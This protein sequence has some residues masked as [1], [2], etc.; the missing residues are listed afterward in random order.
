MLT[1]VTD[2]KI[3]LP[4]N[5]GIGIKEFRIGQA[6]SNTQKTV[7]HYPQ[8]KASWKESK[9]ITEI[10]EQTKVFPSSVS[11]IAENEHKQPWNNY[12]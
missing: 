11:F 4:P 3:F 10:V 7:F 5:I 12:T 8:R 6:L 1:D 9:I 2:I